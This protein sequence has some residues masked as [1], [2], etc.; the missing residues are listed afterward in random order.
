MDGRGAIGYVSGIVGIPLSNPPPIDLVTT[1]GSLSRSLDLRDRNRASLQ[2]FTQE[3]A[4][5][6]RTSCSQGRHHRRSHHCHSSRSS[7][8]T[9]PT[10]QRNRSST[11]PSQP[12][13]KRRRAFG[14]AA[15]HRF[16]LG[17]KHPLVIV[18]FDAPNTFLF[19]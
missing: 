14:S 13:D 8:R 1:H 4:Y 6:H 3:P 17:P 12:F 16:S 15:A 2:G 9:A 19:W 7:R 5:K 18:N 11:V 10:R